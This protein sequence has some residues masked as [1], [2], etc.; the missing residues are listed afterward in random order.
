MDSA[1]HRLEHWV[2]LL[3]S[4]SEMGVSRFHCSDEYESFPFLLHVLKVARSVRPDFSPEFVVKLAEPHFDA[5]G[6]DPTRFRAKLE[7]YRDAL[8]VERIDCVQW[9]WR[10]DLKD[11]PGRVRGFASA[12]DVVARAVE[13]AKS[14]GAMRCVYCFPYTKTFADAAF[15]DPRIDGIAVYR[16]P[17]EME[18]ESLV[19]NAQ[20]S[21]KDVLVIRP[22][23]AGEAFSAD[24][25]DELIKF[26]ARV[27]CVSGIVVSCSSGAHLARCVEAAAEC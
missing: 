21:G 9:M 16:N 27:P 26:S 24:G 4:A 3:L 25:V 8:G 12:A 13:E 11:D 6:F 18:Y 1:R 2:H 7:S 20:Q 19:V 15:V 22:F 5:A 14:I 23:K 10:G 17:L